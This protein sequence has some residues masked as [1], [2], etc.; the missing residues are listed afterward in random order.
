M[1][2]C[3]DC[4]ALRDAPTSTSP[5]AN[6][7]LHSDV[8]IN[9]SATATGRVE[10]YLCHRCGAQWERTRARSEPDATWRSSSKPL[11]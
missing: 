7:L 10:Y 1:T 5:H 6:L 2:P 4:A 11:D 8:A 3:P 9:F